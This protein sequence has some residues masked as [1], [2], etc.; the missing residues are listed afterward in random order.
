VLIIYNSVALALV[1][2]NCEKEVIVVIAN[3]Q[4]P[5]FVR[6]EG[7]IKNCVS[8]ICFYDNTY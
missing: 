2:E 1:D 8:E 6:K 5:L 7:I 4:A 3:S